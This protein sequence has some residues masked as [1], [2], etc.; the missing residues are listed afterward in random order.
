MVQT[1]G[2]QLHNIKSN[3]DYVVGGEWAIVTLVRETLYLYWWIQCWGA[4]LHTDIDNIFWINMYGGRFPAG[5]WE[6]VRYY[7]YSY[8]KYNTIFPR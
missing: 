1:S 7:Y 8:L 2:L 5:V 6:P 3:K 4:N